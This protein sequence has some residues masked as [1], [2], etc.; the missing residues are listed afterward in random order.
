PFSLLC[1]NF[2]THPMAGGLARK[3]QKTESHG[4]KPFGICPPMWA[5]HPVNFTKGS[6]FNGVNCARQTDQTNQTNQTNQTHQTNQTG[7]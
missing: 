4:L 7:S 1:M 5:A 3:S 2:L 6:L